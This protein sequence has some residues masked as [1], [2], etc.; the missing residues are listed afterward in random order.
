MQYA[1]PEVFSHQKAMIAF[2][3]ILQ[4]EILSSEALSR[5]LQLPDSDRLR[6]YVEILCTK[7]IVMTRGRGKGTKYYVNPDVISNSKANFLPIN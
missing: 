2:G 1:Y 3:L 4:E 6:S 5:K 7:N